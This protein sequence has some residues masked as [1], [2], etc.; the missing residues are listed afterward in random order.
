MKGRLKADKPDII[1]A[2]GLYR[3]YFDGTASEEEEN[4]LKLFLA[5]SGEIPEGMQTAAAMFRGFSALSEQRYTPAA[6]YR[7]ARH[8][9]PLAI[10]ASVSIAA[11]VAI[12]VSI[13]S[14]RETYGYRY[15]GKPITDRN[16]ALSQSAPLMLLSEFGKSVDMAMVITD[17]AIGI[18][19]TDAIEEHKQ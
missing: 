15:D 6:K 13:F 11:A 17:M 18:T 14:G 7:R 3:K 10:M 4:A 9:R 5:E 1:L 19:E 12:T 16:E 2:K 8:R